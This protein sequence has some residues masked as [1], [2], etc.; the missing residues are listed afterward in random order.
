MLNDYGPAGPKSLSE[1]P[2]CK[3]CALPCDLVLGPSLSRCV[4]TGA[5]GLE[6]LLSARPANVK[7]FL[8]FFPRDQR[9]MGVIHHDPFGNWPIAARPVAHVPD[10]HA[11]VLKEDAGLQEG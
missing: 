2:N 7:D 6:L 10:P 4:G 1:S 5:S 3:I 8:R 11:A 9:L